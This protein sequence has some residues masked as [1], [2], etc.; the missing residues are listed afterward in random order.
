MFQSRYGYGD[1]LDQ[2]PPLVRA[3]HGLVLAALHD[4]L[5]MYN[6]GIL[7]SRLFQGRLACQVTAEPDSSSRELRF[8][9]EHILSDRIA[10][11]ATTV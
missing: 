9:L 11:D 8:V 3:S 2:H 6:V 4:R 1:R 5:V 7:V 10:Q